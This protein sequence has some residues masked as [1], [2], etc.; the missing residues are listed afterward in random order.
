[1]DMTKETLEREQ[2][3]LLRAAA[4]AAALREAEAQQVREVD[5]G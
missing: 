1:M 3:Q 5:R 4:A 2:E